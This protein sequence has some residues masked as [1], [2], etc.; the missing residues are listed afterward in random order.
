MH[1]RLDAVPRTRKPDSRDGSAVRADGRASWPAVPVVDDKG[2]RVSAVRGPNDTPLD[3][4]D[5]VPLVNRRTRSG[6]NL[7][8][9]FND[10]QHE[11]DEEV[12]TFLQDAASVALYPQIAT[13][14]RE[15][16]EFREQP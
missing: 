8:A 10:A 5:G 4:P 12:R 7:E 16:F 15:M 2:N 6:R 3:D 11:L 13:M 9:A 1:T 14:L